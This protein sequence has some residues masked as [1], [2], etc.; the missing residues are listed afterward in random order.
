M[1]SKFMAIRV[2][3]AIHRNNWELGEGLKWLDP[4]IETHLGTE[5][6]LNWVWS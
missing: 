6:C 5:L 1:L 3:M 2:L 4:D